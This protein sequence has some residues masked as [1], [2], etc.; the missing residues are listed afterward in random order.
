VRAESIARRLF[1]ALSSL[2]LA[3]VLLGLLALL[4]FLGTLAQ[5]EHGLYDVQK[6]YFES[7]LLVHEFGG[8][9][10]PLP[11]GGLVMG[12][13][14]V[15]LALGGVVRIRKVR[16]T[17]GVLVAHVG[18]LVMLAAGFVKYARGVEGHVTLY[19]GESADWFQSYT[20]SELYVAEIVGGRP[21]REWVVPARD[22]AGAGPSRVVEPQGLPFGLG[23]THWYDNADVRPAVPGH[24]SGAPV[25][26]GYAMHALPREREAERNGPGAV[27]GLV[28]GDGRRETALLW[29]FAAAPHT[30]RDG[31]RTF[32]LDLRR[33]RHALPFT[34][35]L[36]DFTK[37]D[38]PGTTMPAWFSSDVTVGSG[39]VARPVVISMNE[40]LREGGVVAYQASWGPQGA[41]PGA[42]LFSTLAVVRNPAD[43]WPLAS[44]VVIALGLLFHFGRMLV[45]H[46]RREVR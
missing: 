4:T 9:P 16:R 12:L 39:G 1:A 19:E 11:G 35:A 44:C 18:M 34:I 29:A 22:L 17:A 5:V 7:L 2:S 31:E 37:E 38:H 6:R 36:D 27:V 25:V 28:T 15:N 20:E 24:A 46:V 40:P 23:V 10:V 33:A 42:P 8:V 3:G 41:A 43:Q 26:A 21:A 45:G 32:V 30:L 14:F 13:L